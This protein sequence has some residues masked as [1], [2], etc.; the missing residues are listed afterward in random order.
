M[1]RYV[2]LLNWTDQGIR[3][4]EKTVD[5]AGAARQAFE[6]LGARMTDLVWCLGPYDLVAMAEAPDDETLTAAAV[7]LA[8]LGNVRTLTLR[9]FNDA[10]MKKILQRI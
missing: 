4:A 1:A 7:G 9:A 2:L 6:K 3:N 10:E 8:K 5:R